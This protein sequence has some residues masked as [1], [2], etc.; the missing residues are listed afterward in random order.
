MAG[1]QVNRIAD[2]DPQLGVDVV[3]GEVDGKFIG[4]FTSKVVL[5]AR[6]S[7]VLTQEKI[8]SSLPTS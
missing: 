2:R 1:E 3:R 6:E 4:V 7:L 8:R 5:A